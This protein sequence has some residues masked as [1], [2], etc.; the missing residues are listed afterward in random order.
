MSQDD[1]T[2]LL[3]HPGYYQSLPGMQLCHHHTTL[4]SLSHL[5]SLEQEELRRV[6]GWEDLADSSLR[7]VGHGDYTQGG[8]HACKLDEGGSLIPVKDESLGLVSVSSR[9]PD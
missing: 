5:E 8:V 7:Q 3:A 9:S 6:M 1:T 4:F 2:C